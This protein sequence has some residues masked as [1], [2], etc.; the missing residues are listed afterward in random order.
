MSTRRKQV[1]VAR[2]LPFADGDDAEEIARVSVLLTREVRLLE[3]ELIQQ[4]LEVDVSRV[5][6]DVRVE[7]AARV[8]RPR[9][10]T[11]KVAGWLEHL[12]TVH[13]Y[14]AETLK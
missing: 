6:R 8:P 14:T 12:G 11:G 3:R 9:E 13:S 7:L 10:V 4:S 2:D 5:D 1:C